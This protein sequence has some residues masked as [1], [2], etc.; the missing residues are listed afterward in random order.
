MPTK[1]RRKPNSNRGLWTEE[2]MLE[3]FKAVDNGVSFYKASQSF[4]IPRKTLVRRYRKKNAAK[5]RMG[6]DSVLGEQNENRLVSHIKSFQESGFPMTREDLRRLAFNFAK[7]LGVHQKFNSEEEKAGYG[8]LQL[9]LS[10]HPDLSVRKSEGVSLARSEGMNKL[11]VSNYF[12]LLEKVLKEYNLFDKPSCIF[13]MDE[14]GI[15]LNNK[16][17]NVIAEKGSKSVSSITS[18]EK[19]ETVSLLACCNA[20]G[21]FL[22]PVAIMKGKNKKQEYE[23]GMPPG[24][25]VYMSQ[26][27]AYVNS[28]LF[29]E[30]LS[31]H[32]VPRKPPGDVILILDG[33]S[34]HCN[35]VEM[36]EFVVRNQIHLVCLPSHTTHYLQPLDRSV[37]RSLKHFFNQ[38]TSCWVKLHPGRRITRLQFGELICE[39]WGKAATT[40]NA[41]SGFKA[42]GIFPFNPSAIPDYAYGLDTTDDSFE[43]ISREE[44]P[45]TSSNRT[46]FSKAVEQTPGCDEIR[47]T[48]QATSSELKDITVEEESQSNGELATGS[49]SH[50]CASSLATSAPTESPSK[51]LLSI[52]AI[53]Q[54]EKSGSKR[55]KQQAKLLTSPEH[56]ASVGARKKIAGTVKRIQAKALP[57]KKAKK[58]LKYKKLQVART[59]SSSSGE[60]VPKL[61]DSSDS[62]IEIDC[63]NDECVGC[64]ENY[65]TTKQTVDWIECVRCTRWLHETCT[66]FKDVCQPCGRAILS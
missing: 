59:D 58:I 21:V 32:F 60:E 11:E 51:V 1:Y 17:C 62:D 18:S 44:S 46:V 23:D 28:S 29:Q 37:F 5:S 64:G 31:E 20:E 25:T 16:A 27:S 47:S 52:A 24:S 41:V 4:G 63:S 36:L 22:P 61:D 8:W 57:N 53:P 19:G 6:P 55:R 49:T 34:S 9:F 15:Q 39:A 56:I 50:N 3:A 65:H 13:N 42:T 45:S 2:R 30:W 12:D 38:A 54:R 33:H 7:Q 43:D 40:Q 48:L 66:S 10:R 35:S 26:K 14:T